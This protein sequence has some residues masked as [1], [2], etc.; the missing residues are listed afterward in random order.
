MLRF[1]AASD[2]LRADPSNAV[3]LGLVALETATRDLAGPL[4]CRTN[5]LFDALAILSDHTA[6]KGHDVA[7]AP[8]AFDEPHERARTVVGLETTDTDGRRLAPTV[9]RLIIVARAIDQRPA[10]R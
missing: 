5:L 9:N 10:G 3:G 7:V 8:L 4:R 6:C 2:P 1:Y